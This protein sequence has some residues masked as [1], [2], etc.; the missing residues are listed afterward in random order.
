MAQLGRRPI[1]IPEE[2]YTRYANRESGALLAREYGVSESTF[3]ARMQ[4]RGLHG[5][6]TT[7]EERK[8]LIA[9]YM[10]GATYAEIEA[11]TGRDKNTIGRVMRAAGVARPSG[12][13][14][15]FHFT[16][17]RSA[18]GLAARWNDAINAAHERVA[19]QR[20]AEAL[21]RRHEAAT[22]PTMRPYLD[23]KTWTVARRAA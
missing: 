18:M 14:D 6:H 9:A 12:C 16:R 3:Y 20:R 8:R 5:R 13:P 7:P 21:A 10:A 1:P 15:G 23:G 2:A 19:A 11:D 4:A 17:E 22:A